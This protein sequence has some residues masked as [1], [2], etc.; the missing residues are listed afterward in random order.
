MPSSFGGRMMLSLGNA[1]WRYPLAALLLVPLSGCWMDS[2]FT[3]SD[4]GPVPAN[5][6]PPE[7]PFTL[8]HPSPYLQ[9]AGPDPSLLLT[10]RLTEAEA[11]NRALAARVQQLELSV[12]D[13]DKQ[14]LQAREKVQA[15]CAEMAHA[16]EEIGQWKQS[17]QTLREKLNT[18]EKDDLTTL[19]SV[20]TVLEQ[21]NQN[22]SGPPPSPK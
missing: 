18:A 6:I 8:A 9:P 12:Q 15:A 13:R 22:A 14:L 21:M 5:P 16:R 3:R 17:V 10:N 7:P 2:W 1:N 20:V 11:Q 19:Q 4:G